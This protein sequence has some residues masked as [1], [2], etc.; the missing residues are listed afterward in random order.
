[1]NLSAA[2]NK[3]IINY[4]NELPLSIASVQGNG[5]LN[6]S[7][8][9]SPKSSQNNP[10]MNSKISLV[11]TKLLLKPP[12]PQLVTPTSSTVVTTNAQSSSS[13]QSIP[14]KVVFVNALNSNP[15][16]SQAAPKQQII[17]LNKP[18]A[19]TSQT[20]NTTFITNKVLNQ[21]QATKVQLVNQIPPLN[22]SS[23]MPSNNNI[24]KV[25]STSSTSSNSSSHRHESSEGKKG[26]SSKSLLGGKDKLPGEK[27]KLKL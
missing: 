11:P 13:S 23:P 7:S 10:M 21:T 19:I 12:T 26:K 27:I 5:I 14:M 9:S 24:A 4:P 15:N 1:M 2:V 17:T 6:N 8:Q 16:A 25:V 20:Q 3:N 22:I 18:Q